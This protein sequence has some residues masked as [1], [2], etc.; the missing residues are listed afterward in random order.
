MYNTSTDTNNK[1]KNAEKNIKPF[2]MRL[3]HLKK[4]SNA[5]EYGFNLMSR[6]K[7]LCQYI[8]IVDKDTPAAKAGLQKGDRIIEVNNNNISGYDL[9][10]I[11]RLIRNGLVQ[12]GKKFSDDLLL[13][14]VDKQTDEYYR[15]MNM[16]LKSGEKDLPITYYSSEDWSSKRN[17]QASKYEHDFEEQELS[18]HF[19]HDSSSLNELNPD[20][21]E[22]I[23]FI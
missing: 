18:M 5:I 15:N 22:I 23:T 10:K 16:P 13:L 8:G 11:V 12:E 6:K 14:V 7:E 2:T 3:C 9:E 4:Q 21:I 1:N 20:D 19:N 17:N